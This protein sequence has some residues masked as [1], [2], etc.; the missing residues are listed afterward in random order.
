M[1]VKSHSFGLKLML[2]EAIEDAVHSDMFFVETLKQ[3]PAEQQILALQTELGIADAVAKNI[4]DNELYIAIFEAAT[5]I[6]DDVTDLEKV[7]TLRQLAKKNGL[8]IAAE[9]I[10]K[11]VDKYQTVINLFAHNIS[12]H[13]QYCI[14]KDVN[15]SRRNAIAIRNILSNQIEKQRYCFNDSVS[16][17]VQLHRQNKVA[18]DVP[19]HINSLKNPRY[20]IASKAII[21]AAQQCE[22]PINSLNEDLINK[23]F[24]V[25]ETN[26]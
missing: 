15:I 10:E 13:K 25:A 26:N 8:S 16:Q 21:Y 4:V 11:M 23:I 2:D 24:A 1:T 22:T 9:L 7:R 6:N 5:L 3:L 19:G 14:L 12:P 17:I 18:E 20:Y